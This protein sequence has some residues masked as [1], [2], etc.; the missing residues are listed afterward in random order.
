MPSPFDDFT[1]KAG[2][3]Y[4]GGTPEQRETRRIL[5]TAME[6]EGFTVN[7]VEWWHFDY[8]DWRSYRVMDVPFDKM[9]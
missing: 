9:K 6:A 4:A 8:K 1:A 5:R 3:H 7:P 2:A